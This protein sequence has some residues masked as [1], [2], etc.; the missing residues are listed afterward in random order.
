MDFKTD[1]AQWKLKA[2]ND[3]ALIFMRKFLPKY[4][5]NTAF[6][7]MVTGEDGALSTDNL[8]AMFEDDE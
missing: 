4:C 7:E 2:A 3:K 5:D 6:I 1:S 8:S